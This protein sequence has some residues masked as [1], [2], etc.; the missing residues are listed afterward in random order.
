[1]TTRSSAEADRTARIDPIDWL[2]ESVRSLTS[3]LT[4]PRRR[5]LASDAA[6]FAID[7]RDSA[8]RAVDRVMRSTP[9]ARRRRDAARRRLIVTAAVAGLAGLA[10]ATAALLFDPDRGRSRRAYLRDRLAG[11][12]RRVGRRAARAGRFL[13]STVA[14]L[15]RSLTRR[16]TTHSLD[17]VSLAHKVETELFRDPTIAK[18][19]LNV[20]AEHGVVFL[21]GTAETTERISDI[22]K[23]TR[24]I[25]GVRDVEN[26]LH[27][28]GTPAR[29]RAAGNGE[30]EPA[31]EPAAEAY[32]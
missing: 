17:D 10:G 1:M 22:E 5:R 32:R 18:G 24:R 14:G 8:T 25:A 26:L 6:T 20:N 7:I 9:L 2:R 13:G 31:P 11:L 19:H 12:V 21:R 28:S 4:D 3:P 30:R 23:R 27:V 16:R 29:S 15:G